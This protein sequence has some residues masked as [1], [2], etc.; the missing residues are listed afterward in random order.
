MVLAVSDSVAT[1]RAFGRHHRGSDGAM[2]SLVKWSSE[3]AGG[4]LAAAVAGAWATAFLLTVDSP[5]AAVSAYADSVSASS[6]GQVR[7]ASARVVD[8]GDGRT[9]YELQ[10]HRPVRD[11]TAMTVVERSTFLGGILSSWHVVQGGSAAAVGTP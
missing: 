9:R 11:L 10:W 4:V 7:L 6:G 1:F 8:Q 5:G 2:I 3:V